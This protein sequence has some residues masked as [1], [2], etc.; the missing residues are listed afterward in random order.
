MFSSENSERRNPSACRK[1]RWKTMATVKAVSIAR[2]EYCSCPPGFRWARFGDPQPLSSSSE[3]HTV[4]LLRCRRPASYSGQLVVLYDFLTYL[5]WLRLNEVIA[6]PGYPRIHWGCN[7]CP[8]VVHQ[9]RSGAHNGCVVIGR[10]V[11][12]GR[13]S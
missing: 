11:R 3:S 9:H 6:D 12:Q 1:P 7:L 2:F 4:R 5:A 13:P 8:R 10:A